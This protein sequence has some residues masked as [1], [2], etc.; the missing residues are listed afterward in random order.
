MGFCVGGGCFGSRWRLFGGLFVGCSGVVWSVQWWR[1]EDEV[2]RWGERSGFVEMELWA[3]AVRV[4]VKREIWGKGGVVAVVG[5]HRSSELRRGDGWSGAG[6]W[7]E[8]RWEK[9]NGGCKVLCVC[10]CKWR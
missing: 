3:V 9:E 6:G 5:V 1:W 8:E 7:K 2:V 10:L 4:V